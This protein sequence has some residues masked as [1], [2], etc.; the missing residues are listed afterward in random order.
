MHGLGLV[1]AVGPAC[2]E[3]G[4]TCGT[5]LDLEYLLRAALSPFAGHPPTSLLLPCPQANG[6]LS[7]VVEAKD[8]QRTTLTDLDQVMMATGGRKSVCIS[9]C[10]R[11][12]ACQ[13]T[14]LTDLDQVMVATGGARACM[15][16]SVC[17]GVHA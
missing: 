16:I 11:V 3:V 10:I 9:V 7:L 1:W 4:K 15:C 12:H 14:T 5:A 13:R 6:K 17:V 8:G 2:D